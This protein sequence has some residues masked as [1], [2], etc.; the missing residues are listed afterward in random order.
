MDVIECNIIELYHVSNKGW[1]NMTKEYKMKAKEY[2][3]SMHE[4]STNKTINSVRRNIIKESL[5]KGIMKSYER[6]NYISSLC[7]K[8]WQVKFRWYYGEFV[9]V[10]TCVY[11]L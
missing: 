7:P 8:L 6:L 3:D 1:K 11:I 2:K 4:K 10:T 5:W 9:Y